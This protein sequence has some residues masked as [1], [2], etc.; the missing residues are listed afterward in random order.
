M[1]MKIPDQGV[2]ELE[3]HYT[4][5]GSDGYARTVAKPNI[6]IELRHAKENTEAVI[7]L[8]GDHKFPI[9]VDA[10]HAKALSKEA[11]DH[12]SLNTRASRTTAFAII[13]DSPV[14]RIIANFFMGLNNPA[15][16]VKL[17]KSED[18]AISWCKK[19]EEKSDG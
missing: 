3:A 5:L 14:S 18:A 6:K 13:V 19:L 9:I 8:P 4:W 17:F 15:V 10:R 12:F 1:H 7:N 2:K 11:R 16:P